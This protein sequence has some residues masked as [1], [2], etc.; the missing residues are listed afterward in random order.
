VLSPFCRQVCWAHLK[1]DF[2]KL[3]DRGGAAAQLGPQPQAIV[4][5]VFEQWHLFRGGG[6]DPARPAAALGLCCRFSRKY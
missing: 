6:L 5:R 3:I 2:E 1:R 4:P